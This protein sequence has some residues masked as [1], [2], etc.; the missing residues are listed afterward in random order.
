MLNLAIEVST[1][2]KDNH[3]IDIKVINSRRLKPVDSQVMDRLLD[4]KYIFT[5]EDG[6]RLGGFSSIIFDYISKTEK[7]PK[8]IPFAFPNEPIPHGNVE[9]IYQRYGFTKENISKKI[10]EIISYK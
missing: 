6:V 4:D 10:I 3:G 2:L 8:L 9:K 1:Y 7:N 5:I